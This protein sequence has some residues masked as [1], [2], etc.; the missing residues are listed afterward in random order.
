[1]SLALGIGANTAI[2]TLLDAAVLRSLPVKEPERLIELLTDRGGR[3][4][5][6][7]SYPA[8][9]YFREHATTVEG[10]VASHSWRFYVS[11]DNAA[12]ELGPGQYVTGDFFKVLGVPAVV[13][14]SV[15]PSDDRPDAELV[16]V[17]G[18]AY[19]QSRFNAD[20][21]VIGRRITIDDHAFTIVGVAP[22]AFRG[23]MVGRA[24]DFW[25]PLSAEPVLRR[26]TWTG[27][28]RVQVAAA[29]CPR[30]DRSS[31]GGGTSRARD[32]VRDRSHRGGTD[33]LEGCRAGSSGAALAPYGCVRACGL[34]RGAG[35]IR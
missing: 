21:L 33:P 3:L 15:E 27:S 4:F 23:T 35:A 12:P 19:W 9:Q 10:I 11:I 32:D 13:G 29:S 31:V 18:H 5:N 20:P 16:A 14:R 28:P 6:A 2:F 7:F 1:V 25:I 26:P 34:V 17:L 8:L 22:S 30:Q 24:V